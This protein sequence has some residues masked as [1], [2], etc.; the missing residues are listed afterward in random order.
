MGI[1]P[2]S[3]EIFRWLLIP[4]TPS[5]SKRSGVYSREQVSFREHI[6]LG[7]LSVTLRPTQQWWGAMAPW[8]AGTWYQ[9][10]TIPKRLKRCHSWDFQH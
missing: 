9:V 6:S 4:R 7:S 5:I 2:G 10:H 1:A 3:V 8:L